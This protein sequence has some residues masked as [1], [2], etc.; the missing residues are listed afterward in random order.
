MIISHAHRFIFIKNRKVG[1]TSTELALQRICGPDDIVTHDGTTRQMRPARAAR[2]VLLPG[3]RNYDGRFNPLPELL[4]ARHPVDAARVIR[5]WHARPKFYNHMRASSVRARVPRAVWDG[6]YK[7]CF[8]RNPWDKVVSFYYWYGRDREL[9]GINEFLLDHRRWGT[10]DQVLPS[11]WV[12]YAEGDRI[13]VDDVFDFRDLAGGLATA[14]AR[15]GVPAEIAAA[16]TLGQAKTRERK[17]RGVAFR[18]ETDA[19]IRR[20]FRREIAAFDFCRAPDPELFPVGA[21][22]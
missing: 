18:P 2:D 14:L 13:L 3:A 8:E 20:A 11:D 6:Y 21:G 16:A 15:A 10:T 1:S 5:D 4:R 22:A 19:L 7:F 17:A 12:R 9:P